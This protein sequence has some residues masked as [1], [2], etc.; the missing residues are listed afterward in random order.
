M[1]NLEVLF[2][3]LSFEL[4]Q[5]VL[6]YGNDLEVSIENNTDKEVKENDEQ[7]EALHEPEG[8]NQLNVDELC[9]D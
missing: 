2:A 6:L 5:Q 3:K 9:Y 8:L 1:H 4:E 7:E